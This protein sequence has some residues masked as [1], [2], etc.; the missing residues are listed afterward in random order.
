MCVIGISIGQ[1]RVAACTSLGAEMCGGNVNV[2]LRVQEQLASAA[3]GKVLAAFDGVDSP[4][5]C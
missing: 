4:G 2:L 3:A 1:F 5:S